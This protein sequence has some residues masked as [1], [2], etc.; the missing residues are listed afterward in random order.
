MIRR[1]SHRSAPLAPARFAAAAAGI[2]FALAASSGAAL[3][4]AAAPAASGKATPAA[5][6][7]PHGKPGSGVS[8]TPVVPSRI[9]I[10][11]TVSVRLRLAGVSAADGATVEVRDPATK[12]TLLSTQLA[13]GEQRT[14]DLPYTGRSDGMQYLDVITT[15]GG[16]SSVLSVPLA[17]GSG[18]LRLKTEG[19]RRTTAD[20][21]A[22][23]SLPATSPGSR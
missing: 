4:S 19:E 3:A 16:R 5:A 22:V 23:I 8:V 11:E 9:G 13:Q 20:G 21:E 14:I 6:A 17:V 7:K 12:L 2:A 18:Q 1:P 10:G 15:Q